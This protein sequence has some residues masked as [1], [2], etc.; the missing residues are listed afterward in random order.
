[1]YLSRLILNPRSRPA[2]RD[3]AIPYEMHKTLMRAFGNDGEAKPGRVLWRLDADRRSGR[4]TILVQSEREPA[5]SRV[6]SSQGPDYLLV[7][8]ES[9]IGENPACK[10]IDLDT[11]GLETGH[12]LRFRLRANPTRK[13][14]TSS[15]ADRLA[16]KARS[17]GRRLAHLTENSQRSWLER[18]GKAGGFRILGVRVSQE[19]SPRGMSK[20]TQRT[21]GG[22]GRRV[23]MLSVRYDGVLEVTD[24]ALFHK[25]VCGGIGSGKAMGFGLL[26]LAPA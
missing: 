13:V 5:W 17:N 3:A 24:G 19:D 26:S 25:A 22:S 21:G 18:K 8:G 7:P 6:L 11:M 15:K 12:R 1:M 4:W 10:R 23:S 9:G 2:R 14:A 20:G 16:G